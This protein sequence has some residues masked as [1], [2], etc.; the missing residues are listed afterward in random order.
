MGL[1]DVGSLYQLITICAIVNP[2]IRFFL[3]LG[4]LSYSQIGSSQSQ[5]QSFC[6]T[7]LNEADSVFIIAKEKESIGK[8]KEEKNI[9]R[10][11][12]ERWYKN[13]E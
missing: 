2:I 5:R 3:I 6:G 7:C 8:G 11:L 10:V 13:V 1:G 12:I 4:F 9:C